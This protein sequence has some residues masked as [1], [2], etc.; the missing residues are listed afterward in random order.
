MD[1]DGQWSLPESGSGDL[2][3]F[4]Y[5]FMDYKTSKTCPSH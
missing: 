5:S 4:S 2:K 3:V 1:D